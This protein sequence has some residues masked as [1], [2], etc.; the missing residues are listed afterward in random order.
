V[1]KRYEV[2]DNF[3][4]SKGNHTAKFGVDF[5]YV[6]IDPARFE[7]N[8][9]GLFNFGSFPVSA[10]SALVPGFATAP[11]LTPVQAYG[12][13]L[14]Q[15][16]VQGF[17]TSTSKVTNKTIGV[18][19]Q[20]SWKVRSNLTL[21]YGIRY[22]VELTPTFPTTGVTSDRFSI[23][24]QQLDAAERALNVIQGI[25]RDKNNFAPRIGFAYDPKGDGKT[26]ILITHYLH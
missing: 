13:G 25:P 14:P 16:F 7:L 4:L 12:S 15:T 5:N 20:D 10:F 18:F 23:T 6:D 24:A 26:V 1:E 17:G 19:A 22:D 2:K 9:S 3:T 21:N 8:F 11:A